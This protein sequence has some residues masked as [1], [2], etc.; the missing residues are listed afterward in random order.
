MNT[1]DKQKKKHDWNEVRQEYIRISMTDL[2]LA[3]DKILFMDVR[4]IPSL[5]VDADRLVLATLK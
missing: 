4:A 1:L 2:F 5:S 3:I